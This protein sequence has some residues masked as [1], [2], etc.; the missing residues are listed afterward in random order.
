MEERIIPFSF[1]RLA[2]YKQAGNLTQTKTN[3]ALG[4]T[5][6]LFALRWCFAS[7]RNSGGVGGGEDYRFLGSKQIEKRTG[8][9]LF[10]R[11]LVAAELFWVRSFTIKLIIKA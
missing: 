11:R 8:W 6:H 3:H 1:L 2:E 9:F 4:H 7:T 5:I 10:C